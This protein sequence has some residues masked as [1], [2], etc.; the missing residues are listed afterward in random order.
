MRNKRKYIRTLLNINF[1]Y[2][3]GYITCT[4]CMHALHG[5]T[6]Y[7]VQKYITTTFVQIRNIY[8]IK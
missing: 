7:Y 2:E 3:I 5:T 1:I 6:N 4:V 8:R